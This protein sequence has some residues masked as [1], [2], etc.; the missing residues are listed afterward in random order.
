MVNRQRGSGTRA[1]LEFIISAEGLDRARMA[2]YE[3]EEITHAAVAALVAGNQAD[4][5]FGVQ[6]AAAN[7]GLGF[8]PV[9]TERYYLACE[10]A[11]LESPAMA[12]LLRALRS[13]AFAQRVARLPGYTV[14]GAGVVAENLDA[15]AGSP[16]G[17]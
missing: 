7:Y 2:G 10:A 12:Q 14:A 11:A 4:V 13:D 15:E 16:Q 17:A 1:L 6:A 9:C 8:V 5:G 3:N